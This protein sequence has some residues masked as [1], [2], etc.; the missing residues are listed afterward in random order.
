MSKTGNLHIPTDT[1]IFSTTNR[2]A[3]KYSLNITFA[4]I[5]YCCIVSNRAM[6]KKCQKNINQNSCLVSS[7]KNNIV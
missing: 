1:S 2:C 7:G 5:V 6:N 4:H 3:A